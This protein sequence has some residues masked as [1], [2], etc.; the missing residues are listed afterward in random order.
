MRTDRKV[1]VPL[2]TQQ[3]VILAAQAG[4]FHKAAR[5]LGVDPSVV[6]RSINR[7]EREL[8]VKLFDRTRQRFSVTPAGAPFVREIIEAVA[9]VER[10]C[11]LSRC[12]AQIDQGALRIGYSAYA[13]S[14]L[15]PILEKLEIGPEAS[16]HSGTHTAL[17]PA[18]DNSFSASRLLLE[19]GTTIQLIDRVQ[20]GDLHA[21]FGVSPITEVHLSVHPIAQ[22]PF[23]LSVS[24][25]HRLAKQPSIFAKDLDGETVFLFP[26][27]AHPLLY[28][29]TLDYI[30][31]T[32]ARPQ[33][34]EVMSFTHSM[35]IVSHNFGVAL[36]PR[37]ASRFSCMGVLFKPITDKLL[38]METALFYS[39][40]RRD[41][42]LALL[43]D[44]MLSQAR[45]ITWGT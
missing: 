33:I 30:E 24:K 31:S 34:R 20:R 38:W 29:R 3:F 2:R 16:Q 5:F 15:I 28:D 1:D 19:S 21:A 12:L 42:R 41:T 39:T 22:E 45:R 25:N 4:S 7:L 44:E 11:D 36:L 37:S 32:G 14:R 40:D 9:H 26:R 35:E 13:N 27:A 6:V 43:L 8:G 17:G 23:S 18:L 10:A